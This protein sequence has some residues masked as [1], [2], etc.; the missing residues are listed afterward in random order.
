MRR[1]D[2]ASWGIKRPAGV[3]SAFQVIEYKVEPRPSSLARNLLANDDS[4]STGGDEAEPFGPEVLFVGEAFTFSGT[5]K[6]LAWTTAGPDVE[7]VGPSSIAQCS[8]PN[9]N[10]A[11]E[12]ALPIACD[13]CG[14]EIS[15]RSL[16]NDS[17]GQFSGRYQVACPARRIAVN[18]RI[19]RS[20]QRLL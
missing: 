10:A 6:R 1:A 3:A 15:D 7:V 9:P 20:R 19:K 8:G 16:I 2:A 18:V 11:E 13:V 14:L 5:R 17:R 12:V 4:R